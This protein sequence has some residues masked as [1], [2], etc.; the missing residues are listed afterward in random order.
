MLM[1]NLLVFVFVFDVYQ[2][3]SVPHSFEGARLNLTLKQSLIINKES[4]T[5]ADEK[6]THDF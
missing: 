3:E 2:I 5:V 6:I 1:S 4:V